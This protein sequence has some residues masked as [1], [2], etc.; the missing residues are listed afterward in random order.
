MRRVEY[1]TD[2]EEIHERFGDLVDLVVD[3]GPGGIVPSTVIDLTGSA[4]ELVREG[5]GRWEELVG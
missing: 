2:P 1:F 3:G 5:A 4:P